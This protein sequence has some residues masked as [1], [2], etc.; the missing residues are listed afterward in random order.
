MGKQG[1][2]LQPQQHQVVS[3]RECARFQ[4]FPD[5]YRFFGNILDKH[6]QV[7]NE[8]DLMARFIGLEIQKSLEWK[9]AQQ[10]DIEN[11]DRGQRIMQSSEAQSSSVCCPLRPSFPSCD[12]ICNDA[13]DGEPQTFCCSHVMTVG[14][15]LHF[16]TH[17]THGVWWW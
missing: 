13:A 1:R 9:T 4:G 12:I 17:S 14:N 15:D 5:T 11:R 7:S 10:P 16:F 8:F 3:V 2:V 6:R